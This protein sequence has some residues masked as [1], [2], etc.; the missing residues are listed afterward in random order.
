MQEQRDLTFKPKICKKSAKLVEDRKKRFK[1]MVS[2][3][4]LYSPTIQ[5]PSSRTTVLV[6]SNTEQP[7]EEKRYI[8]EEYH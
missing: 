2:D 6:V 8:V 5:T 4:N 1:N 3:K 7:T